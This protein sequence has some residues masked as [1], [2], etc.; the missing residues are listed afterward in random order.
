[1][2]LLEQS[3][4]REGRGGGREREGGKGGL[5]WHCA[6]AGGGGGGGGSAAAGIMVEPSQPYLL[7]IVVHTTGADCAAFPTITS[8]Q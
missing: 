6:W 4:E 2:W 3:K 7:A 5:K 1:M 8:A